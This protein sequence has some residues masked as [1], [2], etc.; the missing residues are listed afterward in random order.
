MKLLL[1]KQ[2]YN[3]LSPSSYNVEI[4]NEAAQFPGKE[5]IN[6]IFLAVYNVAVS[7]DWSGGKRGL[8]I[9]MVGLK[10]AN[11]CRRMKNT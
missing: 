11:T 4:R 1:K 10:P 3:V 8:F 9:L 6:W 2:N 7:A 5:Y